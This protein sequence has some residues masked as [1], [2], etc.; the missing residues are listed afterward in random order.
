MTT[1]SL[2]IIY[3]LMKKVFYVIPIFPFKLDARLILSCLPFPYPAIIQ[4]SNVQKCPDFFVLN[5]WLWFWVYLMRSLHFARTFHEL[6]CSQ[7]Y[8]CSKIWKLV[9]CTFGKFW[10]PNGICTEFVQSSPGSSVP[11]WS[12]C[13]IHKNYRLAP[14]ETQNNLLYLG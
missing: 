8:L 7:S 5:R 13:N 2:A 3:K 4:H 11:S 12:I 10:E 14:L 9:A 1:R 6:L